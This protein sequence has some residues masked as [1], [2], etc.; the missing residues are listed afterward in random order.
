MPILSVR[1]SSKEKLFR[2]RAW[3]IS[4]DDPGFAVRKRGK[5]YAVAVHLDDWLGGR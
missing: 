1:L 4:R 5:G 2:A 3:E